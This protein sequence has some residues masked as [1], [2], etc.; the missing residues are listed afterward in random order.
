MQ[1]GKDTK[2]PG[3]SLIGGKIL[4]ALDQDPSEEMSLKRVMAQKNC[5]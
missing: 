4:R 5:C 3:S 2:S 1:F